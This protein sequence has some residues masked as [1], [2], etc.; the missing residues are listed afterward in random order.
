MS[1]NV[2]GYRYSVYA[3]MVR[4]AL[5]E[6]GLSYRWVEVNPFSDDL[7]ADYLALQPFGR[8]P[9]VVHGDFILY[10]T[11]A[12]T[13]YID[14]AFT[15]TK[16]QPLNA[17]SRARVNQ[18]ISIADHYAYWPL[19]R[20]VFSHGVMGP[21]IGRQVVPS[22]VECGLNA[23]PRILESLDRLASGRDF[24][25]SEALTLADV[26]L[27]PMISYFVELDDARTLFKRY[28]RLS[29]WWAA[30]SMRTAFVETKPKL[31]EPS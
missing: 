12:I 2:H 6:K 18:I 8:V 4:F 28:E 25:I 22:E 9:T 13:R 5:H 3:W 20:Q 16:L 31:P 30:V 23:A 14:E 10:E 26:H 1:I 7:P 19:V 29:A 17:A 15:G 27:A 11:G 24:L 21:K